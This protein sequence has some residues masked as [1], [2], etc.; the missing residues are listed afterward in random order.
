MTSK[1]VKTLENLLIYSAQTAIRRKKK[2][3]HFIQNI[4]FLLA[5]KG[6]TGEDIINNLPTLK[7]DKQIRVN[8]DIF[9]DDEHLNNIQTE[10]ETSSRYDIKKILSDNPCTTLLNLNSFFTGKNKELGIKKTSA[11]NNYNSNAIKLGNGLEPI[12]SL[13]NKK[14]QF[15]N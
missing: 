6:F 11:Q 15:E 2:Y 4:S 9:N 8:E 5:K 3:K 10:T 12:I 7:K 1:Y 13:L 14:R